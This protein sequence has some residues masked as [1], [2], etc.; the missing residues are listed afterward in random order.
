M[1][2]RITQNNRASVPPAQVWS[3]LT[4]ECQARVIQF[5]ARL[6]SHLVT[7]ESIPTTRSSLDDDAVFCLEG[8]AGSSRSPGPGLRPPVHHDSGARKHRQHRSAI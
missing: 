5:L 3:G 1:I 6:A 2:A 7:E 4:T 8:P